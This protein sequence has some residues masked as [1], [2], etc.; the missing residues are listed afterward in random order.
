MQLLVEGP[1]NSLK[2]SFVPIPKPKKITISTSK[3]QISPSALNAK[4]LAQ[5][6]MLYPNQNLS[7]QLHMT[8][9]NPN[10]PI[11]YSL[12]FSLP[13]NCLKLQVHN[14]NQRR[15]QPNS[16][17]QANLPMSAP[18]DQELRHNKQSDSKDCNN[19][20]TNDDQHNY[21]ASN[22][23]NGPDHSDYVGVGSK[24]PATLESRHAEPN[25]QKQADSAVNKYHKQLNFQQS[26]MHQTMDANDLITGM[27]NPNIFGISGLDYEVGAMHTTKSADQEAAGKG[28]DLGHSDASVAGEVEGH[29]RNESIGKL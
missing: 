23:H 18:N 22:L 24:S 14:N 7:T 28:K 13:A 15:L 8:P 12:V 9:F 16:S 19:S 5:T 10:M 21:A 17:H 25:A 4:Y 2:E 6:A 27:L 29:D 3:Q 20:P 1:L 26:M 11:P